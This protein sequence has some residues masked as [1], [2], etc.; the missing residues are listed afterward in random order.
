MSTS[1][2]VPK[3]TEKSVQDYLVNKKAKNDATNAKTHPSHDVNLTWAQ[4]A[5]LAAKGELRV[6]RHLRVNLPRVRNKNAAIF[7]LDPV[8]HLPFADICIELYNTYKGHILGLYRLTNPEYLEIVFVETIIRDQ[9]LRDGLQISGYI[10]SGYNNAETKNFMTITLNSVPIMNISKLRNRIGL[11]MRD[12]TPEG[13]IE[14]SIR[15]LVVPD[16]DFLTNQWQVHFDVTDC[17]YEVFDNVQKFVEI[18]GFKVNLHWRKAT[19]NCFFCDKEGHIKKD[20]EEWKL[21]KAQKKE[22]ELKTPVKPD[23]PTEPETI[24]ESDSNEYFTETQGDDVSDNA[25]SP[26]GEDLL[27]TPKARTTRNEPSALL[28]SGSGLAK[29]DPASR[30]LLRELQ[31]DDED[32]DNA[33]SSTSGPSHRSRPSLTELETNLRSDRKKDQIKA[34]INKK[35][36]TKK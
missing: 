34:K 30:N 5:K 26:K 25:P 18:D 14:H 31:T 11:A 35:Q 17:G 23:T 36:K 10:L 13:A 29:G 16:T 19:K 20:C 9:Y 28:E 27:A 12:I 1:K 8:K 32:S 22:A 7:L 33:S 21:L 24:L 15:P 4:R 3:K 2:N 6:K